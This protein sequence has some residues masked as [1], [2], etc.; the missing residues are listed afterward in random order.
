[1]NPETELALYKA[2]AA[3]LEQELR[4]DIARKNAVYDEG[5]SAWLHALWIEAVGEVLEQ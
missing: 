1:M 4:M 5:F 3:K 2:Y